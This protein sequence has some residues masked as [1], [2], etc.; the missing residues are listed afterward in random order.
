MEVLA[1]KCLPHPPMFGT[2]TRTEALKGF[3]TAAAATVMKGVSDPAGHSGEIAPRLK[4]RQARDLFRTMADLAATSEAWATS[5]HKYGEDIAVYYLRLIFGKRFPKPSRDWSDAG[6][7]TWWRRAPWE[8][9]S[10][11]AT[12]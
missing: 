4:R 2:M 3:F 6:A 8:D 1:L 9:P 12:E 7:D 11:S 10:I 5:S